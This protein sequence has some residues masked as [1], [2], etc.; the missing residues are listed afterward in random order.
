[1]DAVVCDLQPLLPPEH[2]C[3]GRCTDAEETVKVEDLRLQIRW[4]LRIRFPARRLQLG[5]LVGFTVLLGQLLDPT[6]ADPELVSDVLSVH[7]VINN[8]LTDSGDIVLVQS[9]LIRSRV[10]EIIPTK[11]LADTTLVHRVD[12]EVKDLVFVH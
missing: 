6:T 1:M 12:D 11:S 8:T 3:D 10:G 4:I 2:V 9:H 5:D 7:F